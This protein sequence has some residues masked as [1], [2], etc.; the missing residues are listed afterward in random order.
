MA[1]LRLDCGR[2]ASCAARLIRSGVSAGRL[3]QQRQRFLIAALANDADGLEPLASLASDLNRMT[4][5]R[6]SISAR[7]M[8]GLVSFWIAVSSAGSAFGVLGFEHGAGGGEP[9]RRIGRQQR[10]AAERRV[11]AA[12]KAVVEADR[13]EVAGRDGI[14]LSGRSVEHRAGAVAD[15]DLLLLRR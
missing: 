11:D 9:P 6:A 14:R 15:E 1:R 7:R 4:A 2:S 5:A 13:A 10:Q 8:V 12:A 3:R